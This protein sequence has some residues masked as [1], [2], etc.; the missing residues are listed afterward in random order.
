MGLFSNTKKYVYRM[1]IFHPPMAYIDFVNTFIEYTKS[2]EFKTILTKNS[3]AVD[4]TELN[5]VPCPEGEDPSDYPCTMTLSLAPYGSLSFE[6]EMRGEKQG[7]EL[8]I[9]Y[10]LMTVDGEKKDKAWAADICKAIHLH[11]ES[12]YIEFKPKREG[13]FDFRKYTAS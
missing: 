7:L 10:L 8:I 4:N 12:T 5:Y 9:Y 13:L 2:E 6:T 11:F 3:F 1:G